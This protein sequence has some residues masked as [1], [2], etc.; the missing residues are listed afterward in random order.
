MKL[1][2]FVNCDVFILKGNT[3]LSLT[4]GVYLG[5]FKKLFMFVDIK[6]YEV[7][8]D[9]SLSGHDDKETVILSEKR[10]RKKQHFLL[11]KSI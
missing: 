8:S 1:I 3:W 9:K 10:T 4:K 2:L 7:V 6:F 5:T 11:R